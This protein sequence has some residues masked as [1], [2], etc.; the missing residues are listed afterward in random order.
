MTSKGKYNIECQ[1]FEALNEF[2]NLP[3]RKWEVTPEGRVWPCCF[4]ANAWDRRHMMRVDE[5]GPDE[6]SIE[7]DFHNVNSE[8]AELLNDAR[9]MTIINEDPDWNSL[10]H[11]SIE[12][13]IAH[14][15]FHSYIWTEGWNSD[16]PAILCVNNCNK[17]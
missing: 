17:C 1:S 9:M 5:L 14:E 6:D 4:F 15:V 16:N 11:H 3:V 8:S 2:T 12:E 10:E 7:E 13:I